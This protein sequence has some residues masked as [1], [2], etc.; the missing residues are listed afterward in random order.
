MVSRHWR[1][2][3]TDRGPTVCAGII[4][5]TRVKRYVVKILPA[6]D[7][8][9]TPGPDRR[10]IVARNWRIR[11][12]RC[13]P[14]IIEARWGRW[15]RCRSGRR[16][17]TWRWRRRWCRRRSRNGAGRIP[18]Q[19]DVAVLAIPTI[20]GNAIGRARSNIEL[21]TAGS[22]CSRRDVVVLRNRLKL[23]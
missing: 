5:R 4:S 15:R 17:R 13:R 12:S 10:V 7:D 9:L 14:L 23:N 20:N 6:P 16:N 1:I 19:R 11:G 18:V 21:N 2:H 22:V 3:G 8:H